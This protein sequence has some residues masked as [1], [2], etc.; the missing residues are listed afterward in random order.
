MKPMTYFPSPCL[1]LLLILALSLGACKAAPDRGPDGA[2]TSETGQLTYD[3]NRPEVSMQ[4]MSAALAPEQEEQFIQAIGVLVGEF[5]F[6]GM[7]GGGLNPADPVLNRRLD[8]MDGMTADEIV[9]YAKE[10]QAEK[11]SAV[12]DPE[13]D[14]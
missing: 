5:A 11:T 14:R 9:A 4:T 12:D 7:M 1:S 8:A 3:R 2:A 6:Q 13:S 10:V